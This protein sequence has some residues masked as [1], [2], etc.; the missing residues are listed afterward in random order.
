MWCVFLDKATA[1]I[2]YGSWPPPPTHPYHPVP[3]RLFTPLGPPT[4]LLLSTF[5]QG[6]STRH[7][8]A[9]VGGYGIDG[10]QALENM[11]QME[12][13]GWEREECKKGNGGKENENNLGCKQTRGR[14][15]RGKTHRR[16]REKREA[17]SGEDKALPFFP[18]VFDGPVDVFS[19]PSLLLLFFFLTQ[20]VE[21][22]SP[23]WNHLVCRPP[24]LPPFSSHI[25]TQWPSLSLAARQVTLATL[26]H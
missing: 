15:K 23:E 18:L 5:P 9:T 12:R 16:E 7:W 26:P 14:E 13:E 20:A 10:W 3:S 4:P 17:H 21:T 2:R 24:F 11:R 22:G 25:C 19:L 6:L 8:R 1:V